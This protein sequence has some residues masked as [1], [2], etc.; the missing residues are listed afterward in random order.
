[1]DTVLKIKYYIYDMF[2]N[3]TVTEFY[4]EAEDAFEEGKIVHEVHETTWRTQWTSGK[5]T[6]IHEWH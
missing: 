5:N 1:M 2:D 4:T 3:L 6:V